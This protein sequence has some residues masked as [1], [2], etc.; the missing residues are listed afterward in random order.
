MNK[1]TYD[2]FLRAGLTLEAFGIFAGEQKSDCF[3]TPRGATVLGWT[4]VDG[5]HYVQIKTLGETVFAVNPYADPGRYA[6]PV[7][8]NFEDFLCL[9]VKCGSE[10]Y[11]E[12]VHGWTWEQYE[13]FSQKYPMTAAQN[14]AAERMMS[15][16]GLT[17][18]SDVYGYVKALDES[19]DFSAIP[20]SR[21]DWELVPRETMPQLHTWQVYFTASFGER[22]GRG[23]RAGEEVPLNVQF[24]WNGQA[25]R[26]PAAY[27]CARGLVVDLI[28]VQ[29]CE[30][31]DGMIPRAVVNGQVC[32]MK[33]MSMLYWGDGHELSPTEQQVLSHYGL[34]SDTAGV[35]CRIAFPWATA[36]KPRLRTLRL[37]LQSRPKHLT[38]KPF[39]LDHA[40]KTVTF[41]HPTTGEMHTLTAC[42]LRRE[43]IKTGTTPIPYT[44]P[45]HCVQLLYTL[46]PD[47]PDSEFS[48]QDVRQS[49]API[50]KRTIAGKTDDFC[51]VAVVN[52]P[53][54]AESEA[55]AIA[56]IGG[57]DGPTTITVGR[58]AGYPALHAANSALTFVPQD[59]VAWCPTFRVKTC[60]DVAVDLI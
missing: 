24:A 7:A 33:R 2:D 12:Q 4:G 46:S 28:A 38:G 20:Y 55:E 27:L 51:S 41:S 22:G 23:E 52:V 25:W 57:S 32:C 31:A 56:I 40:G 6:H 26:V 9:L 44:L 49:D 3:C 29:R 16:L 54:R 37:M 17:P 36:K 50:M 48:L 13:A 39:S 14:E 30:A 60:E 43:E 18:I 8:K 53:Q 35:I 42:E 10:S 58:A 19:F 45:T 5:I 1:V 47:L 59:A 21:D 11:L 34:P 15:Q